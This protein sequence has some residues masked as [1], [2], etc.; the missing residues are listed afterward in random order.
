MILCR[1]L[2]LAVAFALIGVVSVRSGHAAAAERVNVERVNGAKAMQY[3]REF[4][5]TSGR[6]WVG[7]PGHARAEEYIR[8]QFAKDDLVLD[9]FT[10]QTPA[11]PME[12]HNYIVRFP[13]K[14]DGV[15][16]L[17]SHYETNYPLKDV[18]Y[19]GANDGGATSGLLMELAN[20]LRGA[21]PRVGF[22]SRPKLDG[23]S[24]WLVFFDGEEAIRDWSASDS[25]YGSR[26]LAAK[27]QNDGTLK[28]VKAFLLLDMIGDRDLD[29]QRELNS[30]PK[31]LDLVGQAATRAGARSHFY[32]TENAIE[33]DHI[34]FVERGVPCA[35]IIDLDYGPHDAAHP[36]G[37]HHTVEDTLDKVSGK[38]LAAVGDT[39][40]QAIQMINQR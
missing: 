25:T 7:S 18:S 15:I 19:V 33:D 31:L 27:W 12:M 6:R 29:I 21:R 23:Y 16:V 30:T 36:D 28:R 22:A 24:V 35:D 34:P 3:T 2:F 39:V 10:T 40:L 17:A 13:G 37:Y 5:T 11:G 4:V 26:H 38:S 32:A 20:H 14:K 9:S 8:K 1:K